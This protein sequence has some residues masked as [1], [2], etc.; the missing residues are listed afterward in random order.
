[1][2]GLKRLTEE[3]YA[4]VV[5]DEEQLRCFEHDVRCRS[6]QW[7]CVFKDVE[8]SCPYSWPE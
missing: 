8:E 5:D 1:M 6:Q 3:E 7:H 4:R 2:T